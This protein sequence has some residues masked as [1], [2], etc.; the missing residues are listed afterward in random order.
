MPTAFTRVVASGRM[1]TDDSAGTDRIVIHGLEASVLIGTQDWE[2]LT[3][4]RLRFDLV[5]AVDCRRAGA[6]DDLADAVDYAVVG[7]RVHARAAAS[8]FQL[9]EALAEAVAGEALAVSAAIRAVTVKVTK[10]GTV[11]GAE[12]ISVEITRSRPEA[13]P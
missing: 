12:G 3:P 13:L 11:P 7:R 5:L 9:V 6:S 1:A 2:R 8:S 4:Q 10:P